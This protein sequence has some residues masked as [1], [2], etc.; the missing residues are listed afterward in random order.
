[1]FLSKTI[2]DKINLKMVFDRVPEWNIINNQ[3]TVVFDLT[4]NR[5][6]LTREQQDEV[7]IN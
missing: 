4:Q 2:A 1:M 6:K 7:N 5:T 3:R